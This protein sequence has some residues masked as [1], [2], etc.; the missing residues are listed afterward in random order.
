LP[1]IRT[2]YPPPP[3]IPTPAALYGEWEGRE[4]DA[5]R[6]KGDASRR[7][8][9]VAPPDAEGKRALP[10]TCGMFQ[11]PSLEEAAEGLCK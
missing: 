9:L 3:F 7:L 1:P 4:G 2:V 8:A 10:L 11:V 6:S 5:L